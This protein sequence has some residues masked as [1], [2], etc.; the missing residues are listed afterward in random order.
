MIAMLEHAVPRLSNTPCQ[1]C[2]RDTL[3]RGMQCLTCGTDFANTAPVVPYKYAIRNPLQR[4]GVKSSRTPVRERGVP[5]REAA[6]E[7]WMSARLGCRERMLGTTTTESRRA[8]IRERILELGLAS[9][10]AGRRAGRD[11]TWA[12][13]FRRIY[14]VELEGAAG[15]STGIPK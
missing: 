8:A 1:V 12:E 3:H 7:L 10:V 14:R 9:Q 11:E 6:A 2:G 15:G 5:N 13:L 4:A